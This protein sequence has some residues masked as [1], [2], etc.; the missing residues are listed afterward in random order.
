MQTDNLLKNATL[1]VY[2]CFGQ[3]VT[4]IKNISGQTVTLSRNNLVSGLYF[5]CLTQ[6]DKVIATDKL[7]ITD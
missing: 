7:V 4:E 3:T 2:N 6:E 1:T 5:I